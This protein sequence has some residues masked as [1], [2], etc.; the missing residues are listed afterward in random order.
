MGSTKMCL[1]MPRTHLEWANGQSGKK[2]AGSTKVLPSMWT[3][4]L[5]NVFLMVT[6]SSS[7]VLFCLFFYIT[8]TKISLP[9]SAL[10]FLLQSSTTFFHLGK[11]V[12]QR[13]S[14]ASPNKHFGGATSTSAL[15]QIKCRVKPQC[16]GDSQNK[17]LRRR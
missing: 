1:E 16:R 12:F 4:C 5:F 2:E 17:W 14:R 9:F 11:V 6:R 13:L 3:L 7:Q 15:S 8:K 10:L